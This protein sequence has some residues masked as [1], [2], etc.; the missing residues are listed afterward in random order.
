MSLL[1]FVQKR[2]VLQSSAPSVSFVSAPSTGENGDSLQISS[3]RE[4]VAPILLT[5]RSSPARV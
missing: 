5:P 4:L 3:P 1:D 2:M